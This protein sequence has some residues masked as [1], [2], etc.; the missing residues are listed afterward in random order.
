MRKRVAPLLSAFATLALPLFVCAAQPDPA[1]DG[2]EVLAKQMKFLLSQQ[3]PNGSWQ[4]SDRE[5][6]AVTALVLK[7]MTQM[8]D[9]K[10]DAPAVAA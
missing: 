6:V 9:Y 8:P 4:R 3:Q 5:P 1:V 2:K 7:A 10:P